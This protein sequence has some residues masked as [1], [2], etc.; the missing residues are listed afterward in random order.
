MASSAPLV[1]FAPAKINLTLRVIGRR[2]DGYHELESLVAFADT[3]DRLTLDVSERLALSVRGPTAQASGNIDDNLVLKAARAFVTR[4]DSARAGRFILNKTLPVAAGI[5]GGSSDAAA[6]LRL[7]ARLNG[8]AADDARLFD[9]A[10]AI[11]ADVPVCLVP[12]ARVMRGIGDKL[13]AP[14]AGAALP[15][16]LVNPRVAVP[17]KDVFARLAEMRRGIAAAA[18]AETETSSI[19]TMIAPGVN[20]LEAPAV[21]LQPIIADVLGAL[22]ALPGAKLARMSGSGAT[23]F[24]LFPSLRAAQNA[25]KT[26]RAQ[27]PSWWVR[28]CMLNRS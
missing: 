26:L 1:E 13:S 27:H 23:C 8:V 20:D 11:G 21:S 24:A 3:G 25:A 18:P 5:G 28:G 19:E 16:I 14:I 4:F 12:R 22:R 9:I 6:A 2:A 7:L 17:T 10:A 15:A